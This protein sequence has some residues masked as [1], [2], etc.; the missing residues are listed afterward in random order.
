MVLVP[1][2]ETG[3]DDGRALEVERPPVAMRPLQMSNTEAKL[4]ASAAKH[5]LSDMV[6]EACG[7]QPRGFVRGRTIGGNVLE[8]HTHLRMCAMMPSNSL[9]VVL[10]G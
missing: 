8:M 2:D 10:L 4:L 6:G 3:V 1:K 9:A 5:E 7:A